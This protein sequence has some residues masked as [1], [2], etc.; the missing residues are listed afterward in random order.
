MTV[1]IKPYYI[2]KLVSVYNPTINEFENS[3]DKRKLSVEVRGN[4]SW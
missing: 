3:P 1:L 4:L 2:G